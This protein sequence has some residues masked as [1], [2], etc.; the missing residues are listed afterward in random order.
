MEF[1]NLK[2][3]FSP[4]FWEEKGVEYAIQDMIESSTEAKIKMIGYGI[5]IR[6]SLRLLGVPY[7]YEYLMDRNPE[8]KEKSKENIRSSL[9]EKGYSSKQLPF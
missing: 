8:A 7:L 5:L 9:L 2:R 6:K 1:K 4:L 3:I